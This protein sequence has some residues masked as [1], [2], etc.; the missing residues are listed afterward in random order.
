MSLTTPISA[1]MTV[2]PVVANQFHNF[3]Q[4]LRLFTE[5]PIH[6]LPIVGGVDNKLIG[7]IS[8]NDLPKVFLNLCNRQDKITMDLDAI[9]KAINLTDIMTS[10][11]ITVS[12]TE[13]IS[14]AVKIFADK[15][16]M[17]LPVV[18]NGLLVGIL[19]AKDVLGY[20]AD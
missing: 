6:H 18:D 8:S 7:I 2:S 3:S 14:A 1:I 16:F 9:D 11:P 4:V 19:S 15:K 13:P 5:F 10:N 20:I 12:S 17:A